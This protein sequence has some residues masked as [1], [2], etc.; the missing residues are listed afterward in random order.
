MLF[1]IISVFLFLLSQKTCSN[2][3]YT[4]HGVHDY[5]E[6][7]LCDLLILDGFFG[8]TSSQSWKEMIEQ[9]VT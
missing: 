2:Y 9:V 5:Y 1:N 7:L 6:I 4:I 8:N 3:K